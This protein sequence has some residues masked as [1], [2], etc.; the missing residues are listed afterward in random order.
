MD[1]KYA[2]IMAGGVGSRFWP[3]SRSEK[4][5]QF[6]DILGT[7]ET[8]IQQTFRRFKTICPE[9]NIFVVTSEEHRELVI[10]QLGI[11][12][13]RVMGEPLR[14]NTAPCIAYGTFRI[15]K[16]NPDAI[17]AVTPA[18]HL[19]V[20]ENKF[21]DTV[22]KC[23]VFAKDNN[24][25]VTIG[26]KP[27]R[28][29]TGYGYI[30]ADKK[31]PVKDYD[32]LLKVKTFTEK[33]NRDLARVFLESGDFFWNSGIFIWNMKS[34]L[35][36]FEKYMPDVYTAFEEGRNIY[37]T[38]QESSFIAKTYAACKSISIDYGIMEKADNVYVMT[39]TDIGWSDLGTWGSLYEH[40][41]L[42][43]DGNAVVRG[44]IFSYSNN[45]NIFN[46]APG[47]IAVIQGLNDYI[48]IDV[49]D[50]LLIVK[51]EEE[52]NIKQ[53]LEEVKKA[54]GEKYL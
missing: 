7:G 13:S 44:D 49:D 31:K 52:Q 43:K 26:I 2:L 39:S 25:L 24:A 51:K 40:S 15:L 50:I 45:G 34:I 21:C 53:Y 1:N 27:D 17:I 47:K 46:I 35:A 10:E 14:R 19:I 54:S 5:K 32:N 4:P 41:G 22:K 33:P 30:Q 3:L 29:E 8:L 12:S 42:D 48:V 6:L 23:F 11:D 16:E 18:D 36:A 38:K 20:K 28:P 9:E 37:S